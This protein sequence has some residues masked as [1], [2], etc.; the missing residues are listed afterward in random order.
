M[1]EA[2]ASNKRLRDVMEKQ[3]AARKTSREGTVKGGLAGAAE[4]M[5]NFVTQVNS[6]FL[7]Q[8]SVLY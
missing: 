6:T 8:L 1:E 4:R 7:I 2:V 5:R 3:K